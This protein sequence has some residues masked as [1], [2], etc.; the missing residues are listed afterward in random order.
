MGISPHWNGTGLDPVELPTPAG[1][2]DVASMAAAGRF[3]SPLGER[4]TPCLE[5][6]ARSAF[7]VES[8]SPKWFMGWG[9]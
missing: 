5:L 2:D 1:P 4:R 6:T 3:G 9:I 8:L 7:L